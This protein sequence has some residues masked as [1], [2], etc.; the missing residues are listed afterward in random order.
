MG[1]KPYPHE[2]AAK[3]Q[4]STL[5]EADNDVGTNLENP[6]D[7]TSPGELKAKQHPSESMASPA[8]DGYSMASGR[9]AGM[10]KGSGPADGYS[11]TSA[12]GKPND[13]S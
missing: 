1:R 12:S 8:S 7:L 10:S 3:N 13:V 6:Y 2:V 5:L 9:S 4:S 11:I